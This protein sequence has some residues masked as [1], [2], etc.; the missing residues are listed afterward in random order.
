MK[1]AGWQTGLVYFPVKR[2]TINKSLQ[3]SPKLVETLAKS[4][5]LDT[6]HSY[7]SDWLILQYSP[8]SPLPPKPM[9]ICRQEGHLKLHSPS[10]SK[11]GKN[12]SILHN[13]TLYRGGGGLE[14]ERKCVEICKV[15]TEE[16]RREA[17]LRVPFLFI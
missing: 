1:G 9:S 2:S 16:P 14:L 5:L 13:S 12:S 7:F 11:G 10:Y 8:T 6:L 4:Y 15:S 17:C 3:S